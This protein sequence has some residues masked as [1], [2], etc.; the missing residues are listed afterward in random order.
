MH[1]PNT[2]IVSSGLPRT[3]LRLEVSDAGSLTAAAGKS[4]DNTNRAT[5]HTSSELSCRRRAAAP[6][7]TRFESSGQQGQIGAVSAECFADSEVSARRHLRP[8]LAGTIVR[9]CGR[10]WS[11]LHHCQWLALAAQAFNSRSPTNVSLPC[12]NPTEHVATCLADSVTEAH[13]I[14]ICARRASSSHYCNVGSLRLCCK[15]CREEFGG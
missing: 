10:S 15:A 2:R 1:V 9:G 8:R 12:Y 3:R 5:P 7:V 14:T 11:A 4:K 6:P 13:S